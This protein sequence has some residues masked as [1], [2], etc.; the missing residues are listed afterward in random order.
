MPPKLLADLDRI[1]LNRVEDDIEGI[2][3]YNQQRFEMEM[4]SGIAAFSAEEQYVV[5]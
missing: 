1:D 3:N 5:A 4:L 2:R